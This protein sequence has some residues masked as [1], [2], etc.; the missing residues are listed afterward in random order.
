MTLASSVVASALETRRRSEGSTRSE[1][2][3]CDESNTQGNLLVRLPARSTCEQSR[4][5]SQLR[6]PSTPKPRAQS[7]CLP[8]RTPPETFAA[9][10]HGPLLPPHQPPPSQFQ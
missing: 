8:S 5:R 2:T 9:S 7:E 6:H 3:D 4:A 1:R 10:C